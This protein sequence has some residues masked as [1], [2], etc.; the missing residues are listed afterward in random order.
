MLFPSAFVALDRQIHPCDMNLIK[1]EDTRCG[2]LVKFDRGRLSPIIDLLQFMVK[3]VDFRD[4]CSIRTIA[5]KLL[6]YLTSSGK[7][8]VSYVHHP[9]CQHI[10]GSFK[11]SQ[12]CFHGCLYI[13]IDVC[14]MSHFRVSD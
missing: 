9:M 13:A 7:T 2:N 3:N 11:S 4:G 10:T 8:I 14:V 12:F 6:S 5:N 1:G